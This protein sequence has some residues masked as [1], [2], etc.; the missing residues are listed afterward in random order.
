MSQIEACTPAAA[1]RRGYHSR[2]DSSGLTLHSSLR[3]DPVDWSGRLE[4]AALTAG[5]R[6]TIIASSQPSRGETMSQTEAYTPAVELTALIRDKKLSPVEVVDSLLERID[7]INP[8]INAF[9]T[10]AA[11]QARQAAPFV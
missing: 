8:R 7:R 1:R 4:C 2:A 9:C 6:T 3:R 5:G 10:V 11:D